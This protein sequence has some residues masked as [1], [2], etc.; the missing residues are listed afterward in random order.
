VGV[1]H[2]GLA[3]EQT[4]RSQEEGT[5]HG[6]HLPL[7]LDPVPLRQILKVRAAWLL[8]GLGQLNVH[9]VLRDAEGPCEGQHQGWYCSKGIM[10]ANGRETDIRFPQRAAILGRRVVAY[11]QSVR[12]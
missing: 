4:I 8:R 11:P 9:H 5:E 10:R 3:L 2:P 12:A 1:K 7:W 6:T